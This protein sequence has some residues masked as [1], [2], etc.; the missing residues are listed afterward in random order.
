MTPVAAEPGAAP[1]ETLA[2]HAPYPNPTAA[3]AT[4]TYRLA[5]A[6]HVTLTVYD[7]LG[8]EVARPVEGSRPACEHTVLWDGRDARGRGLSAGVYVVRLRAGGV[9]GSRKVILM[10]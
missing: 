8:R 7:L 5:E 1:S 10:R 9:T 6:T 2:L 3:G 4:L